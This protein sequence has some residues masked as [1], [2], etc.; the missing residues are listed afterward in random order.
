MD[1]STVTVAVWNIEADGGRSGEHRHAAIDLLAS[2]KPDVFLQQEAKYSRERGEQLKYITEKQLRLR[3]FLSSPNPFIDAD[4]A[5]SLYLRPEMFQVVKQKP[6][7]KTWY[8]HPCH[9]QAQLGDCPIP[10]NL[11]S[12]HM[13]FFDAGTRLTEAGWLTTLAQPGMVT[14]AAGDTNSY[15]HR[16][17]P[18][19]LPV[20][21]KVTDRAHMVH[22]TVMDSSGIRRSD[23]G[24]DH[25]L[26]DAEYVDLA[27]HAADHLGS[28]GAGA[29]AATAGFR[30]PQQGGPQRID[31]GYAA[32]GA[33]TAL[34]HVEVIEHKD[35]DHA[36]LLYRFNRTRLERM[37]TPSPRT[38]TS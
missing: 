2:L 22:R 1:A 37:L 19:S 17:E 11:A 35:F 27:R 33:A 31:R 16:L 38:A 29:L 20:W 4:I 9:V 21:E 30:K 3:G 25:A 28:D 12:F 15:P 13:C 10:L 5:T 36:L 32:G 24:P 34:E 14:I 23:T 18:I 26:I 7:A 6:C 8:L